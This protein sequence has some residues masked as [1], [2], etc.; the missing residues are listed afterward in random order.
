MQKELWSLIAQLLGYFWRCLRLIEHWLNLTQ[1]ESICDKPSCARCG[2]RPWAAEVRCYLLLYHRFNLLRAK[3]SRIWNTNTT[4]Q[5]LCHG[6]KPTVFSVDNVKSVEL[7]VTK[8]RPKLKLNDQINLELMEWVANERAPGV[9]Q[10]KIAHLVNQGKKTG[11][12]DQAPLELRQLLERTVPQC[13]L[14]NAALR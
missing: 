6:Q 4:Y 5:T 2:R 3:S 10:W 12:F 7:P 11:N 1:I 9:G 14:F 8:T 13:K